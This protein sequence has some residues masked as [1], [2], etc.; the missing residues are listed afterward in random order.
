[1]SFADVGYHFIV[2]Q[3]G[4]VYEGRPY[5]SLGAH[6]FKLNEKNLGVA[7]LGCYD[8]KGC[9]KEKYRLCKV[10][11]AMIDSAAR[12]IA[13]V[14]HT[15]GF[16]IDKNT[17][18]PRAVCEVKRTGQLRFPYSPGELITEKLDLL[19][20]KARNYRSLLARQALR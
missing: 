3:S 13:Y 6:T 10:T 20:E 8:P 1:M 16:N 15:E 2:G 11:D 7:F 17:V 9:A 18:M 19:I 5:S 4:K 12:V 14:A